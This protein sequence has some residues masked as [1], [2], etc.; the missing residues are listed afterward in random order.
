MN[1]LSL[2]LI[3]LLL[4]NV[5]YADETKTG[6]KY[7]F[8]NRVY[9]LNPYKDTTPRELPAE[10]FFD[11]FLLPKTKDL[12]DIQTA[13]KDQSNRG[14]CA[15][16]SSTA[17]LESLIKKELGIS[18]NISEEY[19]I[20]YTK[21]V[22]GQSSGGDGSL[23]DRNLYAYQDGFML[24]KDVPYQ[25][26]W[27]SKGLPCQNYKDDAYATP[28][29]CYSHKTPSDETLEKLIEVNGLR[30]DRLTYDSSS[31]VKHIA[32]NG[33]PVIVNVPVNS[34]GWNAETGVA[35]HNEELRKE[36]R[37]KPDLCGSHSILIVGYDRDKKFFKFKNSWSYQWGKDG[38]GFMPFDFI[39]KYSE[40]S[41]LIAELTQEVDIPI[42]YD[43]FQDSSVENVTISTDYNSIDP[44]T[45]QE[46][47]YTVFSGD[48][49]NM[50]NSTFYLSAYI[51]FKTAETPLEAEISDENSD[52]LQVP[53][54]LQKEHGYYAKGYFYQLFGENGDTTFSPKENPAVMTI[55]HQIID[56]DAIDGKDI[57]LRVSA[58]IF[59]D[60]DGWKTLFREY[61][62]MPFPF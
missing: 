30:V 58:Y 62:K 10:S 43:V 40:S 32:K 28:A 36:C 29:Y 42:D 25:P 5:S 41:H 37:E 19:L 24:E 12:T 47:I 9:K 59:N 53:I 20:Y 16:F 44:A 18:V 27:F 35:I 3:L 33:S 38:Y 48:V 50:K 15:Y 45:N 54:D 60:V 26:S 21:A 7:H 49:Y 17:L 51:A 22:L 52:L 4:I 8:N 23:P 39:D 55:P 34:N 61:R 56:M 31:I 11:N 46:A 1:K 2:I 14:S 6:G 13:V 57:Y